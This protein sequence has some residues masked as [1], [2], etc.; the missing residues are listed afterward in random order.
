[1]AILE[2]EV[3]SLKLGPFGDSAI[4]GLAVAQPDREI[5]A[6]WR[7]PAMGTRDEANVR[8]LQRM[9]P[10]VLSAFMDSARKMRA[11]FKQYAENC[12]YRDADGRLVPAV[13]AIPQ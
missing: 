13:E 3:D 1:M 4:Q 9:E 12:S 10:G 6:V 5:F 8:P 7:M 11:L 2:A